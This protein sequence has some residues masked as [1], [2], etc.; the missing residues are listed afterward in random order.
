[1]KIGKK[2]QKKSKIEFLPLFILLIMVY[3][4]S[5]SNIPRSEGQQKIDGVEAKTKCEN[6]RNGD[7]SGKKSGHKICAIEIINQYYYTKNACNDDGCISP[8]P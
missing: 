8:L 1:V 5:K 3:N 4:W 6:R 2:S 7:G